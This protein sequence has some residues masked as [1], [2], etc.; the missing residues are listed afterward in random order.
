MAGA[1]ITTNPSRRATVALCAALPLAAIAGGAAAAA[2]LAPPAGDEALL[3]LG[4]ELL[5]AS[6][7][8]AEKTG[9][10]FEAAFAACAAIVDKIVAAPAATIAGLRVKALAL[11]WCYAFAPFEL[12]EE[13]GVSTDVY[14]LDS[15]VRDLVAA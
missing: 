12:I 2:A 3:A 8:Y 7:D 5:A 11:R 15:I 6:V 9:D 1:S 10:E 13:H 14:V 4:A